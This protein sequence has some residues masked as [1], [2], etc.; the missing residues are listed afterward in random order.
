[1][2][3][4]F[5]VLV[6]P[7]AIALSACTSAGQ[8]DTDASTTVTAAASVV[9]TIKQSTEKPSP[10]PQL[11][12][13]TTTKKSGGPMPAHFCSFTHYSGATYYVQYLYGQSG[14]VNDLG[15]C[16]AGTPL[17]QEQF[18]DLNLTRECV[19]SDDLSI[20][21]KRGIVSY[22]SDGSPSGTAAVEDFCKQQG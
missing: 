7:A 13:V 11:P 5:A 18:I 17:T 10:T 6:I 8:D 4:T 15:V 22:Y 19:L 3:R 2:K 1:M 9:A 21:Q 12:A 14:S 16:T 20:K